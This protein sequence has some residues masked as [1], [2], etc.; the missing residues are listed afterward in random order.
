MRTQQRPDGTGRAL[1]AVFAAL[2]LALGCASL[3]TP[4]T[5]AG[6]HFSVMTYNV[7]WGG[8][9]AQLTLGAIR[10]A[11]ADVV[12][13]QETTPDWERYLR[14][15]LS[16]TYPHMR[17]RHDRGA[18]GQAVLSRLPLTERA[19]LRPTAGWFPG[20]LLEVHSPV[21]PVQLLCVHLRP[22]LNDR[23][24]L[25]PSSYVRT[26]SIRLAEV[27]G[28]HKQLNPRRAAVVLGDFN[29]DDS[30]AAVSWLVEHGMTDALPEFDR[31]TYTWEWPTSVVTFRDRLDHILYSKHLHCHSARVLRAGASDHFPV[32]AVFGANQEAAD[33]GE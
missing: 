16:D 10:S 2:G 6:P 31:S 21:G 13:L 7:N 29:E 8:P 14:P 30:G 32:I 12:C 5:P 25:T 19:F 33:A 24:S 20:W 17:F 26:R 9:G 27:R 1:L 3:R 15:R 28:F 22:A 23:G 18:G 4:E 11:D